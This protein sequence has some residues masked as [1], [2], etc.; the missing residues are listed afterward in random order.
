V[1]ITQVPDP[2]GL[3]STPVIKVLAANGDRPITDNA[4]HSNPRTQMEG[5][6][7]IPAGTTF[8]M[9]YDMLVPAD[10]SVMPDI[11]TTPGPGGNP[12]FSTG[13]VYGP[14]FSGSS[15][16]GESFA[17]TPDDATVVWGNRDST[18]THRRWGVAMDALRGHWVRVLTHQLWA[19][20]GWQ[21]VWINGA[22][23]GPHHWPVM[24]FPTMAGA[25]AGGPNFPKLSVYYQADMIPTATLYFANVRVWK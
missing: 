21:E 12:W 9:E 13:Q 6:A 2:L 25:N 24:H 3:H 20:D 10:K 14:P 5:P 15:E 23:D 8:W 7:I 4:G 18:G 22:A 11:P 1:D 16:A 19:G 17:K